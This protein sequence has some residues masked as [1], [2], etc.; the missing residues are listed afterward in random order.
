L[1][2][3]ID[4]ALAAREAGVPFAAILAKGE[5]HFRDRAATFRKLGAI[6]LLPR[7]TALNQLLAGKIRLVR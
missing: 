2:D 3:N 5:H 6:A 7:A 1:G 4:D